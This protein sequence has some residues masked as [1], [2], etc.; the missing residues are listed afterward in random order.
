MFRLVRHPEKLPK[1]LM[2]ETDKAAKMFM[3]EIR[4]MVSEAGLPKGTVDVVGK[5]VRRRPGH[6]RPR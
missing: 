5:L 1:V 6:E 2:F 3:D 4:R